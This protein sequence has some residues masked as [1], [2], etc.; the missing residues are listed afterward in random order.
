MESYTYMSSEAIL[1]MTDKQKQSG[2]HYEMSLNSHDFAQLVKALAI[3][4]NTGI[5]SWPGE[6]VSSMAQTLDIEMI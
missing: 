3:V 4:H 2:K 6:F 5:S 1:A